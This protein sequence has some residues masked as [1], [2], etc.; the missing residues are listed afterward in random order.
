MIR[1][2]VSTISQQDSQKEERVTCDAGTIVDYPNWA[3]HHAIEVEPDV[4]LVAYMGN[5]VEPGQ[6]DIRMVRL[7][8]TREGLVLDNRCRWVASGGHRRGWN[9]P[10]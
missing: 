3:N 5:I 8:V 6:S 4:V 9:L 7:R 1:Y 2:L 10:S